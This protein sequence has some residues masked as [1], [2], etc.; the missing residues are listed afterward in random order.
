MVPISK[1]Y[2]TEEKVF[3]EIRERIPTEINEF[4]NDIFPRVFK[5]IEE[6]GLRIHPDYF[7]KHSKYH[8]KEWFIHGETV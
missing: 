4:Y 7:N 3:K 1:I 6:Q 2:E 8:E 5:S